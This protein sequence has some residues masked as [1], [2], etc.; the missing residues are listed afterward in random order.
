M[1]T[2]SNLLLLSAVVCDNFQ[3]EEDSMAPLPSMTAL[4]KTVQ[5]TSTPSLAEMSIMHGAMQQHQHG[6]EPK[7]KEEDEDEEDN[8][9]VSKPLAPQYDENDEEEEEEDDFDRSTMAPLTSMSSKRATKTRKKVVMLWVSSHLL[10]CSNHRNEGCPA[11]P[12]HDNYESQR[13]LGMG[14]SN[15]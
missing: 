10:P 2:S 7:I 9:V 12:L 4:R 15:N 1:C 5:R 11:V 13:T 8:E 3:K 6:K 14:M